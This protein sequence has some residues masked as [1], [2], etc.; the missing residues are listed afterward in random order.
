MRALALLT[1]A[2]AAA[3]ALAEIVVPV[4]TIRPHEVIE[5]VDIAM[6]EGRAA[7]ALTRLSQAVG[8]EARVALYAGRP[9]RAGDLGPPALVAR[10]ATVMLIFS[11]NGLRITTEG[12]ALD[13]A[14]AGETVRV[15]NLASR[16]TV[17]GRVRADGAIE[18]R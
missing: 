1:A 10:N 17:T 14:A 4:R 12:R 3:P 9:L 18:V 8:K 6:A 11:R 13:R 2:L 16:S 7:G 5:A 15:M